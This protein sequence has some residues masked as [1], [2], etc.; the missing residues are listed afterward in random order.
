MF[1]D[2]PAVCR[3]FFLRRRTARHL[4]IG[5]TRRPLPACRRM[6]LVTCLLALAFATIH[7]WLVRLGFWSGVP[8]SIWLSLAGGV[9]VAYVFLHILPDLA[10]L[11]EELS[12]RL[13]LGADVAKTAVFMVGLAGLTAFYGLE[14]LVLARHKTT[15][16]ADTPGDRVFWIHLSSFAAYNLL[17]GYL[18]VSRAEAGLAELLLYGFAMGTHF[19]TTDYG[20]QSHHRAR[21][22]FPG[23]WILAA[24]VVAGWA[25]G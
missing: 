2:R 8:R 7:L 10:A 14:R 12:V 6:I 3:A 25:L 13:R 17:I 11:G 18:L 21:Y 1:L 23:R 22:D 4:S 15:G 5:G 20:L 19:L 24:S 16:V 9:A